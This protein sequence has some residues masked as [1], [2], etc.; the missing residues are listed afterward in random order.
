MQIS[1]QN[2]HSTFA[3]SS[4]K[5][6]TSLISLSLGVGLCVLAIFSYVSFNISYDVAYAAEKRE[7]EKY[8]SLLLEQVRFLLNSGMQLEDVSSWLKQS[9]AKNS[10]ASSKLLVLSQGAQTVRVVIASQENTNVE[11]Y[12]QLEH[13]IIPVVKPE[14]SVLF[15][16]EGTQYI[17]IKNIANEFDLT[18]T[19]VH[20]T[21]ALDEAKTYILRRLSIAA[22]LV[23]WLLVWAAITIA[24]KLT[25]NISDKNNKLIHMARYDQITNMFNKHTFIAELE[26]QLNDTSA[27]CLSSGFVV[28]IE[29]NQLKEIAD[30]FGLQTSDKI[31][32]SLANK[33]SNL[34]GRLDMCARYTDNSLVLWLP[35]KSRQKTQSFAQQVSLELGQAVCIGNQKLE[36]NTTIGIAHFP[37][38]ARKITDLLKNADIAKKQA[39]K[40]RL[41]MQ[42]YQQESDTD[43]TQQIKYRSELKQ[44]LEHNQF[45]LYYQPKVTI[46]EGIVVGV[47]ALARWQHPTDG[48]L[49]PQYFMDLIEQSDLIH[50]FS[51]YVLTSAIKQASVWLEQDTA[52]CVA[53]NLSPYNLLDSELVNFI[54][55]QLVKYQLPADLLEIEL[56]ESATMVNLSTTTRV[57]MQ[58]R[59]IGVRLSIDDFGTGMSSLA[60]LQNIDADYIKID[61]SFI[62][63]ICN[64]PEDEKMLHGLIG[65][66]HDLNKE[67][68]AEGVENIEQVNKLVGMG[69]VLVQ[70]FY[71]GKPVP[72]EQIT[73]M[74]KS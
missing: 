49:S 3:E 25:Q 73:K 37:K 9:Y 35:Q 23:F 21:T 47:E 38:D 5:L 54:I 17:A 44:A 15:A 7:A 72:A 46:P 48:L 28:I 63:N 62:R 59:E 51:R 55:E 45:E 69:C 58:L 32:S 66:C 42:F 68:V 14:K 65:L 71:F 1:P 22:F 56:T 30:T 10:A 27:D 8:N 67:V 2:K 50:T 20:P 6:K 61:R 4:R 70:G 36:V 31:L 16:V 26:E 60:Y 12:F 64:K 74:I 13:I 33:L 40:L 24:S 53:V 29:L 57:F 39:Q 52:I 19:Y 43:S 34:L 41:T 11:A 18:I